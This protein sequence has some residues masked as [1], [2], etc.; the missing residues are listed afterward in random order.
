MSTITYLEYTS[1]ALA[2]G[3][4]AYPITRELSGAVRKPFIGSSIVVQSG[5]RSHCFVAPTENPSAT[6]NHFENGSLPWNHLR[7]SLASLGFLPYFIT[8]WEKAV[9]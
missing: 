6:S 7:K 8:P 2:D 5:C 3:G 1:V 4:P 9:W